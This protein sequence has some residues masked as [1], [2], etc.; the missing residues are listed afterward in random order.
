ML[1]SQ[2]YS[3]SISK[4][5][6]ISAFSFSKQ[7][8]RTSIFELDLSSPTVSIFTSTDSVG[9]YRDQTSLT[10]TESA[11]IA[12]QPFR[13]GTVV[14]YNNNKSH[15]KKRIVVPA[16][17]QVVCQRIIR[18]RSAFASTKVAFSE[19]NTCLLHTSPMNL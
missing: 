14:I 9:R 7:A 15:I 4:D 18:R 13:E 2:R 1:S 17:G 12:K 3:T 5:P 16:P 8:R 19:T 6:R 10:S 11:P